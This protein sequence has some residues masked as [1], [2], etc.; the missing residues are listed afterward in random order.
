MRDE[1]DCG[2]IGGMKGFL[3]AELDSVVSSSVK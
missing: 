3:K 1:G 2:A